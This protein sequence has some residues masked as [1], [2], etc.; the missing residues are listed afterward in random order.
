MRMRWWPTYSG[1]LKAHK[2]ATDEIYDDDLS[3]I[4]WLH[5]MG[6]HETS[7]ISFMRF[8]KSTSSED[9]DIKWF[10]QFSMQLMGG[11]YYTLL[12]P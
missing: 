4:T 1:L 12:R 5:L 8:E 7:Y 3:H 11:Q 6:L 10:H 2:A 9:E